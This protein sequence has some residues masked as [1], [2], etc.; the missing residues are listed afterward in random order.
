MR[1]RKLW[2]ALAVAAVLDCALSRAPQ[3]SSARRLS[4]PPEALAALF[5]APFSDAPARF[6]RCYGLA[7]AAPPKEAGPLAEVAIP[8]DSNVDPPPSTLQILARDVPIAHPWSACTVDTIS[9][10]GGPPSPCGMRVLATGAKA[11][12]WWMRDTELLTD[13]TAVGRVGSWGCAFGSIGESRCE[14]VRRGRAWVR[15]SCAVLWQ[16]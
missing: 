1:S 16:E 9:V 6:D 11:V 15:R 3:N 5:R 14:I 8:F 12:G 4:P 10:R 2:A 13:S 7:P